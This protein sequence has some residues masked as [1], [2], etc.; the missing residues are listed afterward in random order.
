MVEYINIDAQAHIDVYKDINRG[1]WWANAVLSMDDDEHQFVIKMDPGP[2]ISRLGRAVTLGW[3]MR[4]MYTDEV[5]F[6]S[7]RTGEAT[8]F[9]DGRLIVDLYN[10]P[11]FGNV[12]MSGHR[13]H[14]GSRPGDLQQDWDHFTRI[15]Y[16]R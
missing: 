9:E 12:E 1:V 2:D 6:G 8:F 5:T 16:G 11:G 13:I 15:A 10:V 14:G 7:G 3:R 4:S